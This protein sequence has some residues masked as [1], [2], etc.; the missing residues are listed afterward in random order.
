MAKFRVVL[1]TVACMRSAI[2]TCGFSASLLFLARQKGNGLYLL[3]QGLMLQNSPF[4]FPIGI[5]P[6]A[7]DISLG[8][9]LIGSM[10]FL[11]TTLANSGKRSCSFWF[12]SQG[13][14]VTRND[15]LASLEASTNFS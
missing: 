1:P 5:Y 4:Y 11:A 12:I 9:T 3:L 7:L 2:L 15:L 13:T 10:V 8:P 14:I 6:I